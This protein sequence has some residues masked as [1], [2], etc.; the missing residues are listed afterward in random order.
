MKEM[1][2]VTTEKKKKKAI[3]V[4][5]IELLWQT[6]EVRHRA[7]KKVPDAVDVLTA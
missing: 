6:R 5:V 4:P 7:M 2:Y 3:N 1:I